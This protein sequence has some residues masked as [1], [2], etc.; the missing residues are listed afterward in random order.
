MG[1]FRG[2]LGTLPEKSVTP[3]LCWVMVTVPR[4]L[5][6]ARARP[7]GRHQHT[8]AN[9]AFPAGLSPRAL[10]VPCLKEW[11]DGKIQHS[12]QQPSPKLKRAFEWQREVRFPF[13]PAQG[14]N[15]PQVTF[16]GSVQTCRPAASRSSP[17]PRCRLG[18]LM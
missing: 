8:S 6:T 3:S 13:C 11:H 18:A 7:V 17:E 16:C 14:W 15:H 9:E 2:V 4:F 12:Q 10:C 1:K 5:V